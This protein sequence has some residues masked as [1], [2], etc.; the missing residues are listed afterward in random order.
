MI[1]RTGL[2]GSPMACSTTRSAFCATSPLLDRLGMAYYDTRVN[3]EG[4]PMQDKTE[5]WMELCKQAAIEQDPQ[6]LLALVEEINALLE[7]KERRL[8]IISP[9]KK[10]PE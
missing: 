6:K 9:D 7:K 4:Y 2:S 3:C 8:G 10:N 1:F 5:R